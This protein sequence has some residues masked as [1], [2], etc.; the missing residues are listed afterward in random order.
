MEPNPEGAYLLARIRARCVEEGDCLIWQG[1]ISSSSNAS[2]GGYP[3]IKVGY[4]QPCKTVR[5]AIV[6]VAG[7]KNGNRDLKPRQPVET[8]CGERLCV[9]QEHLVVST[10]VK[11]GKRMAK[12]G[13]LSS[14]ARS[15]KI[16]ASKRATGK[17]TMEQALEIRFSDESG[18]VLAERYGVHRSQINNIKRGDAW[19]DHRNPYAAL[20]AR[21]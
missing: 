13:K 10:P 17:L 3:I 6:E 16:A 18:P 20:G 9:A 5:R 12:A 8:T 4:G 1:C 11:V 19:R 2:R 15:A 7:D 14:L 21:A